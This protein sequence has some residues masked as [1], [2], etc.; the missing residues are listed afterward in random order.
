M[1]AVEAAVVVE[2]AYLV[3]EEEVAAAEVEV[4][5]EEAAEVAV[6]WMKKCKYS[7]PRL[8]CCCCCCFLV[9]FW[10]FPFDCRTC[11]C[12]CQKCCGSNLLL[13]KVFPFR[14]LPFVSDHDNTNA[15]RN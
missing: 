15:N 4:V 13:V 1:V 3:A 6:R 11:Y 14:Y 8:F 5:E 9:V 12:S 2:V 10:D 7:K